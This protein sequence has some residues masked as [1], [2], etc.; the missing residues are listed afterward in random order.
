[1]PSPRARR[2]R[3]THCGRLVDQTIVTYLHKGERM[4]RFIG[5]LDCLSRQTEYE[6]LRLMEVDI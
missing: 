4:R 2:R 3:C 6:Q 5:C 1:M